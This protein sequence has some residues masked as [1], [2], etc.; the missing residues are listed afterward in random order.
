MSS[1]PV[2]VSLAAAVLAALPCVASA[3]FP[4]PPP[5]VQ[6]RWPEA[7][8]PAQRSAQPQTAQ[9]AD[10]AAPAR[11]AAPAKP[12][13]A[14]PP[15]T[16][17]C[18]GVFGKDSGHTKLAQ[19]FDARNVT[20]DEVDGP[21]NTKINASVLYARD[22][23]RRLEVLWSNDATRSDTSVIVI[24]GQ[25]QWTG[26]KG[27]KLGTSLPALEKSNGRPFKVSAFGADGTASV[28]DWQGG[29]FDSLPGG[30]KIG[31]RMIP[32]PQAAAAARAVGDRELLSNDAQLRAAKPS[33]G[34][35]LI[36]Y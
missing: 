19:R 14:A 15:T 34:E 25:S 21:D 33:V 17:S 32:D 10:P 36:G 4:A 3:Q 23:K 16:V 27:L 2:R 11:P 7:Q 18:S 26:P 12:R 28:T 24:T 13:A 6:D 30:C 31:I 22:P 35:I 5:P 9:P 29:A 20:Y 8:Q 1:R